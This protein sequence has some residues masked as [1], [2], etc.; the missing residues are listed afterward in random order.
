[1]CWFLRLSKHH[2]FLSGTCLPVPAV[3]VQQRSLKCWKPGGTSSW[4]S[5]LLGCLSGRRKRFGLGWRPSVQLAVSSG[6]WNLWTSLTPGTRS[7]RTR[8]NPSICGQTVKKTMSITMRSWVTFYS[9]HRKCSYERLLLLT[10]D[11]VMDDVRAC[12]GL[13]IVL[14]WWSCGLLAVRLHS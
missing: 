8:I 12:V 4:A 9:D 10:S 7:W 14:A 1:M 13:L 11:S 2:G 5:L 6:W 3:L